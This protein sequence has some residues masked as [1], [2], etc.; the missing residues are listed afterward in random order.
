MTWEHQEQ[1]AQLN[2]QDKTCILKYNMPIKHFVAWCSL[3]FK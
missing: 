1:D 2:K 3:I